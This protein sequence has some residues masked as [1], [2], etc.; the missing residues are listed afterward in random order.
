MT[1]AGRLRGSSNCGKTDFGLTKISGFIGCHAS[2]QSR[3]IAVSHR[4]AAIFARRY[5]SKL[6]RYNHLFL[7]SIIWYCEIPPFPQPIVLQMVD[8]LHLHDIRIMG[9][10]RCPVFIGNGPQR[11]PSGQ[12]YAGI[13]FLWH[14]Y[15][16]L[17][18][19]PGYLPEPADKQQA[20]DKTPESQQEILYGTSLL[21][22]GCLEFFPCFPYP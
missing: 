14:C 20:K 12:T 19:L 18:Y 8:G 11:I 13:T 21:Q 2:S 22:P 3:A 5:L 10:I 15:P 6:L 17:P 7:M 1:A 9:M 16:P 4:C